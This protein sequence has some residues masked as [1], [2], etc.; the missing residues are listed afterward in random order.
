MAVLPFA[1]VAFFA[2]ADMREPSADTTGYTP[3]DAAAELPS[4]VI[5][6]SGRYGYSLDLDTAGAR[7]ALGALGALARANRHYV[8]YLTV[9]APGEPLA[10]VALVG[11]RAAVRR[12]V[13]RRLAGDSAYLAVL[14][15]S[16]ARHRARAAPPPPRA[17]RAARVRD[18]AVRFFYPDEV[19]PDGWIQAHVCV[20][21]NGVADMQGVRDLAVEAFV[22]AIFHDLLA[23][24]YDVDADYQEAKRLINAMD[25]STDPETRLRRAQ[26][27][28]WASMLR[29]GKLRQVLAAEYRRARGYLPFAIDRAPPDAAE[30]AWW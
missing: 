12:N 16:V 21:I 6:D 22:Y 30:T 1:L 18:V 15:T 23:T 29:S 25:L 4:L 10:P 3:R 9:N 24:V 26:G 5:V 11:N 20:G 8:L 27:M 19:L 2:A 28:M 14:A 7:G 17:V 13:L